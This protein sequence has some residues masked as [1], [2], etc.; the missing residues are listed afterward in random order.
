MDGSLDHPSQCTFFQSARQTSWGVSVCEE[1]LAV[2]QAQWGQP[3]SEVVWV[4]LRKQSLGRMNGNECC[5]P[6]C[7]VDV[8]VEGNCSTG[9]GVSVL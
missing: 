7:W 5:V 2:C 1:S 3:F 6:L 9:I 4:K 8:L